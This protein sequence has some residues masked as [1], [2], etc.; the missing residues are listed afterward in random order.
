M[1]GSFPRVP[2]YDLLVQDKNRSKR[3]AMNVSSSTPIG[4][5]DGLVNWRDQD[6][7]EVRAVVENGLQL[8]AGL[9]TQS[10]LLQPIHWEPL[11]PSST[12]SIRSTGSTSTSSTSTSTNFDQLKEHFMHGQNQRVTQ[13]VAREDVLRE[14]SVFGV[15][16]G[17]WYVGTNGRGPSCWRAALIFGLANQLKESDGLLEKARELYRP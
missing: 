3:W 2:L 17:G 1:S 12:S 16:D 6:E 8:L 9:D 10:P 15:L 11:I 7:T 4:N 13:S 5:I 14:A